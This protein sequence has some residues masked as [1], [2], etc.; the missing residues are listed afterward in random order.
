MKLYVVD[1]KF[2]YEEFVPGGERV[3]A[4][5]TL[6]AALIAALR[7][8]FDY[9]KA[10]ATAPVAVLWTDA[11]RQWEPLL[12]RLRTELPIL[13]LGPYDGDHAHK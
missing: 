13:T 5:V 4:P 11:A 3:S 8:A 9:N 2:N 10:D 6:Y 7:R 12:P 1:F